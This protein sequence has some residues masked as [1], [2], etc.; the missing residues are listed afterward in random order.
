MNREAVR[1]YLT[2][3][4]EGRALLEELKAPLLQKRDELLAKVKTLNERLSD[5]VRRADGAD[6]LLAREREA[7]QHM[8]V[9][10]ALRR[11]LGRVKVHPGHIEA[12]EALIKARSDIAVKAD[13]QRR[14]AVIR[15]GDEETPLS[16]WLDSWAD[17]EEGKGYVLARD[18]SG[19]GA[20]G[21]G[22]STNA[23]PSSEEQTYYENLLS[24]MR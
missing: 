24:N 15:E 1:D 17:S 12:V 4:D 9:D 22:D 6:E 19:G 16:E 14:Y 7:V 13:G 8:A 2:D 21:S 5:A 18:N 10:E 20:I 11:E 3:N 23:G